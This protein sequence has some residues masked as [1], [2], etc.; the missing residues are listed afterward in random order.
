[1]N[2]LAL[3]ILEIRQVKKRY[4]TFSKRI[5]PRDYITSYQMFIKNQ[6]VK[7]ITRNLS[8]LTVGFFNNRTRGILDKS[9]LKIDGC[10]KSF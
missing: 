1:L 7:K 5:Y 9:T 8:R 10:Q 2:V 4:P 3:T 6:P